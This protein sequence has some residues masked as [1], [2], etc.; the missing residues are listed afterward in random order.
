MGII[1]T[2]KEMSE[3]ASAAMECETPLVQRI[4]MAVHW[5]MC[6]NC[7]AARDQ[8][9]LIHEAAGRVDD[10]CALDDTATHLPPEVAGRIKAM[11]NCPPPEND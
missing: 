2:C 5:L 8:M 9:R 3:L 1:P 6:P 10:F 7:R 11:L 4:L